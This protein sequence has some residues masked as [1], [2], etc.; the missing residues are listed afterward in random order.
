[1]KMPRD[2]IDSVLLYT[3]GIKRQ[4]M[5]YFHCQPSSLCFS[6][7]TQLGPLTLLTVHGW[8][9]PQSGSWVVLGEGRGGGGRKEHKPRAL[10]GK[11]PSAYLNPWA[12][13]LR[14][15]L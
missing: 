5:S 15:S 1:M 9:R 6:S 8:C 2:P 11:A 10:P 7:E 3:W 14:L 13:P 12:G 4:R